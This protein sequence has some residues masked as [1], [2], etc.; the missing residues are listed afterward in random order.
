MTKNT[1]E[2]KRVAIT[3]SAE[4]SHALRLLAALRNRKPTEI[5]DEFLGKNGLK[6]ALQVEMILT[7]AEKELN[8]PE[9][10]ETTGKTHDEIMHQRLLASPEAMPE[11][12]TRSTTIAAPVEIA[13]SSNEEIDY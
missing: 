9:P 1:T 5:V 3:L 4:I 8:A 6:Q 10:K 2:A 7:A 13:D 12:N 11:V